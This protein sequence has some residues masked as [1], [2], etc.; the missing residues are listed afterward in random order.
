M[1]VL[2]V[3]VP[4]LHHSRTRTSGASAERS[5]PCRS[6]ESGSAT[7]P[8]QSSQ[9]NRVGQR[10]KLPIP[11]CAKSHRPYSARCCDS[12]TGST[13]IE[14]NLHKLDTLLES[15]SLLEVL[16]FEARSLTDYI[17]TKAIKSAAGNERLKDV[18]DGISYGINSR[19]TQDFRA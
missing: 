8:G 11:N 16:E 2:D 18:L 9:R 12:S 15:L 17:D 6:T 4:R 7:G 14:N 5:G 19:F 10:G 13:R 1:E 3:H